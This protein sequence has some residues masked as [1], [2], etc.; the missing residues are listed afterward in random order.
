MATRPKTSRAA[1][2]ASTTDRG[3]PGR[4]GGASR[5]NKVAQARK[6]IHDPH[7][8]SPK[9]VRSVARALAR[10]WTAQPPKS[11]RAQPAKA[12]CTA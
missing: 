11:D 6:L 9:V 4:R 7:Y 5:A 10:Q 1:A 2:R 8:P 12:S 3:V